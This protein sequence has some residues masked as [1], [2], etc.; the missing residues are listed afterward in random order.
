MA[1][2]ELASAM[3]GLQRRL[4]PLLRQFGFNKHGRTHNRLTSDGLTHVVSFQM[5]SYGPPGTTYIPGLRENLYGRFTVNFGIYVPEVARHHGGGEPKK[6][7]HDYNCCIRS[8]LR[9][10]AES[11]DCWWTISSSEALTDEIQ[12]L[13]EAEAFPLFR[14]FE[15]RDHILAEFGGHAENND[16]ISVPRIVCAIIM[17]ERG[18]RDAAQRLLTLQARDHSRNPGHPAYVVELAR[19]LGIEIAL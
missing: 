8:R 1:K 7:I 10:E 16:L 12:R 9:R 13:L 17:F 6:I 18:E 11:N 2:S 14:R 15:C 4:T 5:G 3:D 19:R